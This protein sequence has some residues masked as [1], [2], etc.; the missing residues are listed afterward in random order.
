MMRTQITF[1]T[2]NSS[3]SS[4]ITR[5]NN[6]DIFYHI[7]LF[8]VCAMVAATI[9][10]LLYYFYQWLSVKI[11]TVRITEIRV[12]ATVIDKEYDAPT[13]YGYMV[14]KVFIPHWTDEHYILAV[15]YKNGT[16]EVEVDEDAYNKY[17]KDDSLEL[18]LVKHYD[19]RGKI[20]RRRMEL[21]E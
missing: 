11:R 21:P 17:Q 14:G 18:V 7:S 1:T 4:T 9:I 8:I 20:I 3:Y 10:F 5:I 16:Y 19:R 2:N 6:F 13:L 12:I 15:K